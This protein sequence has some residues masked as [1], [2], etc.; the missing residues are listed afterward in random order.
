MINTGTPRHFSFRSSPEEDAVN[1]FIRRI[2][3]QP[4]ISHGE[5]LEGLEVFRVYIVTKIFPKITLQPL[6]DHLWF[7]SMVSQRF[8]DESLFHEQMFFI[9]LETGSGIKAWGLTRRGKWVLAKCMKYNFFGSKISLA[10]SSCE[11]LIA[12]KIQT[13]AE[14][15]FYLADF[16]SRQIQE[17]REKLSELEEYYSTAEFFTG[18]AKIKSESVT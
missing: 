6:V 18:I 11:E 10:E 14:I 7:K 2:V 15:A 17:R 3:T 12:L 5:W 9:A 8:G 16:I 13:P 4:V 1:N